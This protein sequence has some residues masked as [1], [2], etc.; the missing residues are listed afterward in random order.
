[1]FCL[2]LWGFD[3]IGAICLF[4]EFAHL[5]VEITLPYVLNRDCFEYMKYVFCQ[6]S[7]FAESMVVYV[8]KMKNPNL[9]LEMNNQPWTIH[10][11]EVHDETLLIR[12]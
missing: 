10:F 4:F 5:E 9:V 8:L 6:L 1:M 11:D 12:E 2:F 3:A 7:V